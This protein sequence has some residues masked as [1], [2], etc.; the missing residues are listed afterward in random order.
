[1]NGT[2]TY[3]RRDAWQPKPRPEWVA[4]LNEIGRG[5]NIQSV[6]PL[7]IASLI[8]EA[9]RSTGLR[10]YERAPPGTVAAE[11]KLY[12]RYQEYFGVRSEL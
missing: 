8:D 12:E 10:V 3:D 9:M 2:T 4:T 11:R 6:V 1:M 5:L 7:T